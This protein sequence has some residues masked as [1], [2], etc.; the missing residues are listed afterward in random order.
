MSAV[1]ENPEEVANPLVGVAWFG[2]L[3]AGVSSIF[4]IGIA[5]GTYGEDL[6]VNALACT[7][8]FFGFLPLVI[9]QG[10]TPANRHLLLTLT[11]GAWIIFFAVPVW[12]RYFMSGS[13]IVIPDTM[14]LGPSDIIATLGIVLLGQILLLM[15]YASPFGRIFASPIPSVKHDWK[16]DVAI[17]L[18]VLMVPLGMLIWVGSATGIIPRGFGSGVLGSVA[19]GSFYGSALLTIVYLRFKKRIAL[20]FLF[21]LVPATMALYFFSAMKER[22]FLA[23]IYVVI[24][25]I[26]TTRRINAKWIVVGF[27]AFVLFYPI[28]EVFRS[29]VRGQSPG[30]ILSNPVAA[31]SDVANI[32]TEYEYGGYLEDGL[33]AMTTRLAALTMT[34]VVI[35][36]TPD[37]VPYQGGWTLSYLV[38]TFIP[39]VLWPGKPSFEV[40]QFITDNYGVGVV[41]LQTSTATSWIA[42]F[43]MNFGV[44]G[45]VIGMIAMGLFLRMV[46]EI[47]FAGNTIPQLLAASIFAYTLPRSLE[48]FIF[49]AVSGTIVNI[50]PIIGIHFLVRFLGQP[51]ATPGYHPMGEEF[52]AEEQSGIET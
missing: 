52:G 10:R 33:N 41:G 39:R 49:G 28:S 48:A 13:R 36:D 7:I 34:A 16:P 4:G 27:I 43:Y 30:E 23:P 46:H 17:G 20:V 19:S 47:A 38:I 50:L 21:I 6:I 9:D 26:V 15:G 24:A 35:H 45:V 8:T 29:T 31:L 5:L 3:L 32:Q 51:V 42:D 25:L 2:V 14:V 44:P 37:R 18:G 40:G 11:S 1:A 12:S 22:F